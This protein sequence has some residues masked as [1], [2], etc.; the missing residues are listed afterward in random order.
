MKEK[1][2]PPPKSLAQIRREANKHWK[3]TLDI[4][5]KARKL[6]LSYGKY[7]TLL[8]SGFFKEGT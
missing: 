3:N 5:L 2:S 6:N 4:N 1:R 8:K 7:I